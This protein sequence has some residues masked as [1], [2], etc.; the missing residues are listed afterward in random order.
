MEQT[1]LYNPNSLDHFFRA[2]FSVDI[3][4]IT[5][6]EKKL[7][8]L[9][10]RKDAIPFENEWGLPGQLILPNEDTDQAIEKLMTS[11]VSHCSFYKKQLATFSDLGRHPLGR[12]VTFAYYGLV[13][14]ERL[15]Q[16]ISS[17][18][19]WCEITNLPDLIIDH[20]QIVNA[21][22]KRFRKG[23]LRHPIV[24]HTLSDKFILSEI[25]AVYEQAFN[26]KLDVRNFR[27]KLLASGLVIPLGENQKSA[28][29][30]GRP[31]QLYAMNSIKKDIKDKIR[32]DLFF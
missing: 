30:N 6:H 28:S 12:V 27:K 2:A 3:V 13:P 4:L 20:I 10:Q 23:L 16:H 1:M 18:T 29:T 31:A 25:I 15:E 24:F 9:L 7:K 17:E 32:F 21:V 19:K 5:F 8:I 22:I 14:Y 26:K 11:L